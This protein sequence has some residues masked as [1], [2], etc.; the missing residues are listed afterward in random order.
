MTENEKKKLSIFES[1]MR[2]LILMH[3]ELKKDYESMKSELEARK[4]DVAR[5][6]KEL[7]QKEA[8]YAGLKMAKAISSDEDIEASKERLSELVR[9]VDKC[10][11]LLN[12]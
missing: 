11:A 4:A 3:D 12:E 1:R 5:L 9:E 7:A 8:D 6:E 10:I 2:Y